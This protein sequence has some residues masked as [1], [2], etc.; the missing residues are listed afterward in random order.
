MELVGALEGPDLFDPRGSS[1]S[2]LDEEGPVGAL[3]GPGSF[4]SRGSSWS[5]LDEGTLEAWP[6]RTGRPR[7]LMEVILIQTDWL[8]RWVWRF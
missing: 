1:W 6:R 7:P 3:E 5:P 2:P 4:D 8:T